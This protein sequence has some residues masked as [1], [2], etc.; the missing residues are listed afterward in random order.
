MN[1]DEKKEKAKEYRKEYNKE[2][3]SRPEV[4]EKQ[5]EYSNRP[6][7]KKRRKEY[8]R[9]Y[10]KRPEVKEKQ[11]EYME[12]YYARPE[13]IEYQKEYRKE[14]DK[15]YRSRPEAREYRRE[16]QKRPEVKEKAKEYRK[17]PDDFIGYIKYMCRLKKSRYRQLAKKNPSKYHLFEL[18]YE[19]ILDKFEEQDGKCFYSGL[20]LVLEK[21]QPLSISIDRV[22]NQKGYTLENTVLCGLAI[23]IFKGKYDIKDIEEIVL[24]MAKQM[25]NNKKLKNQK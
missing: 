17:R 19:Q 2:Y 22:D 1:K 11:K 25:V 7:V 12:K 13:V 10:Q 23:N 16:Y 8:Q 4:I 20:P 3:R 15:K 21:K 6:E 18:S 14:Y 9:E 24:A 5:K